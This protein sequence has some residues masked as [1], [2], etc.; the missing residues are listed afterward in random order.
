V[1]ETV[2][3]A[4]Q[5]VAASSRLASRTA[6]QFKQT[7]CR[8]SALLRIFPRR[9]HRYPEAVPF[10]LDAKVSDRLHAGR[11]RNGE[12]ERSDLVDY[13]GRERF[14]GCEEAPTA[15]I[16]MDP[17]CAALVLGYRNFWISFVTEHRR[18][19]LNLSRG[20][21]VDLAV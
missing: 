13:A 19:L 15:K 7:A 2:P 3:Q 21:L 20:S 9:V 8:T 11:P 14:C 5:N 10:E 18:K 4:A 1:A 16:S 6:L 17:L 12:F